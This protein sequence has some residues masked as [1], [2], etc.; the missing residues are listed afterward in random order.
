MQ[1]V[2]VKLEHLSDEALNWVIQDIEY[3]RQQKAG[4]R[5]KQWVLD[6]HQKG[7]VNSGYVTDYTWGGEV[8]DLYDINTTKR[9]GGAGWKAFVYIPEVNAT[10]WSKKFHTYG[11]TRLKA[12][13]RCVVLSQRGEEV[14]IPEILARGQT[15]D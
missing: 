9:F 1:M 3:E 5:V 8:M 14:E 2:K 4:I 13:M 6:F 10:G 11:S 15:D 12:A 7:D